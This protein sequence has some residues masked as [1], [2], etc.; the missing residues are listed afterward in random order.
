MQVVFCRQ[1]ESGVELRLRIVPRSKK[2]GPSWDDKKH[3]L[4]WGVSAAPVDGQAND[5]LIVEVSRFFRI[6]KTNINIKS[7]LQ[8]RNKCLLLGGAT[9]EAVLLALQLDDR[10]PSA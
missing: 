1:V 9:V 5:E 8:G 3:E 10:C 7:G 6:P 2:R 4:R